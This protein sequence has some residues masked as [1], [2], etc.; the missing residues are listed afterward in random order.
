[1]L[2]S[3]GFEGTLNAKPWNVCG[4]FGMID[5]KKYPTGLEPN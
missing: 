2:L 4:V 1:M 5:D 3:K